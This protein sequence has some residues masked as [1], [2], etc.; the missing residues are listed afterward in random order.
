[1][2]VPAALG[3]ME[4]VTVRTFVRALRCVGQSFFGRSVADLQIAGTQAP[5]DEPVLRGVQLS[6]LL[7]AYATRVTH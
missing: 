1:M 6:V 5:I 2:R 7:L 4:S 3:A